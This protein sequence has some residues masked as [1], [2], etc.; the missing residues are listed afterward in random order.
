MK[1]LLIGL[2]ALCAVVSFAPVA[3]AVEDWVE[4]TENEVGDRFLVDRNSI[5]NR[6]GII[7]Y[8]EYRDFQEPNNAF[9]G[10]ELEQ[11]VYGA[12]VYRSVDCTSLVS[13]LR[14]ITVHGRGRQVIHRAVYDDNGRLVQPMRGSSSAEVLQF[15][16][17]QDQADEAN[18]TDESN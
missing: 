4:V 10:V 3:L 7:W 13:R 1:R 14:R 8:W 11:P 16:C 18:A 9:I 2:T 17:D 5:E 6:E 12:L 15:V